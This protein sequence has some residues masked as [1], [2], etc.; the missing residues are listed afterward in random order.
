MYPEVPD[1]SNGGARDASSTY[2][3]LIVNWLEVEVLRAVVGTG[4]AQETLQAAC[5]GRVY[6]WIYS[7]VAED[8]ETIGNVIGKHGLGAILQP[9]S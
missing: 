6:Q 2:L 3:H 5:H 1:A 7:R 8:R 9:R 4:D